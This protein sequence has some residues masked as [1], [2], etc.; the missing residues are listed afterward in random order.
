MSAACIPAQC[1]IFER[2]LIPNKC[3][4]VL[5]LTLFSVLFSLVH[6]GGHTACNGSIPDISNQWAM[7]AM[8]RP[9]SQF[10]RKAL[11]VQRVSVLMKIGLFFCLFLY[12]TY[13]K[14]ITK[15]IRTAANFELKLKEK[16]ISWLSAT[17]F[18]QISQCFSWH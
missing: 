7:R 18:V 5:T 8:K 6:L 15:P 4:S 16:N 10:V 9:V 11:Y 13:S 3:A 1:S 17:P 2:L 14:F 12:T